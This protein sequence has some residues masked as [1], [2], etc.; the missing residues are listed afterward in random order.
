MSRLI[1]L[2]FEIAILQSTEE[3]MKSSPDCHERMIAQ[4]DLL[5]VLPPGVPYL[6]Q[7][8]ADESIDF[9]ELEVILGR[10]PSIVA[11]LLS[12]ANSSWVSPQVP[13]T[14]LKW[15]CSLLGQNLVRS[16][17]IALSVSSP[18]DL[19]RCPVFDSERF[20]CTALLAADGAVLLASCTESNKAFDS[21]ALHTAGLLHNLGLLWLADNKPKETDRAL[22][23]VA[24]DD[25]KHVTQCLQDIV[26]MDY[27]EVGGCLGRAWSL[28][29]IFVT[30]MEHQGNSKLHRCKLVGQYTGR[31]CCKYGVSTA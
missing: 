18:F 23:L 7:A 26:G 29:D 17:S 22:R 6:L 13:V 11:R 10:F 4:H 12:L 19:T 14:S 8:L 20:W 30:I 25:Q 9:Q 5:P 15:A 1:P 28:P 2:E 21:R 31:S 24:A 27:C 3:N 16:V